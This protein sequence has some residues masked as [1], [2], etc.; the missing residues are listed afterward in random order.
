MSNTSEKLWTKDFIIMSIINFVIMIIFYLL[1]VT[2][3]S[4]AVEEF[5]ASISQA[6]LVAGIYI[7][8]TLLGRI[9]TGRIINHVGTKK[10]LL[11]GLILFPI[12]MSFYFIQAGII[13]LIISRLVNGFAVGIASTAISTIVAQ[14]LP[15]SRKGEG[16]GY[17]S[18]SAT[19]GTAIG[20][21]FGLLLSQHT[22]YSVIFMVCVVFAILA[23]VSALFTRISKIQ[24]RTVQDEKG[25]HLSQFIDGKALPIS[26]LTLLFALGYASLIA[27]LNFFAEERGLLRASSFFFLAYAI[28]VL[29]TRPFTGRMMDRKGANYIIYPC[30]VLFGGGLLLLS[31]SHNSFLLLLSGAII[32]VGFGN[33]SSAFQALAIKVTTPEKMGLATSTYFIGL[34][35]GLGFGPYFLGYLVPF[36]G[37]GNLFVGLGIFMFVLIILY[38]F[39][40]GRKD[41]LVVNNYL[42]RDIA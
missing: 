31:I 19:L 35:I 15:S 16:I 13:V 10:I 27:F 5:H 12:T 38:L 29:L 33:I 30:A 17:F 39:L 4:Y 22:T 37:Y 36:L 32:G 3:A 40:H 42:N 6:G 18:M 14:T 7:V 41:H 20:P 1:M 24:A 2:M 28:A 9:V 11:I 34:D 23:L 8:G 26:I 25:F 21:F